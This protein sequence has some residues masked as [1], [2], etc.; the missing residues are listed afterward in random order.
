[1]KFDN[2][3]N[4]NELYYSFIDDG[5]NYNFEDAEQAKKEFC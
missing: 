4:M 3:K 2:L 1:M 5:R